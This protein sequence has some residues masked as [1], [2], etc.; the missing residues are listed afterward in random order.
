MT[1]KKDIESMFTGVVGQTKA[2]QVLKFYIEGHSATNTIPHMM[3]VAPK[4][5]GKTLMARSLALNLIQK[6]ETK[7]KSRVLIN[8]ASV[9]NLEQF[10]DQIVMPKLIDTD[11]T[12]FFDECHM[13]PSDV[14]NALLTV[15]NPNKNMSN[16][17]SFGEF[18]WEVDFRRISFIF[19]TTE[20]QK[21]IDPLMDRCRR[22]DLED[23]T[24]EDL[25]RMLTINVDDK[26]SFDNKSLS[27]IATTLRGNG[28]AAQKMSDDIM[29][30]CAKNRKRKFTLSDWNRL[31]ESLDISPLGLNRT[32]LKVLRALS[33]QPYTKLT[34]LAAKLGMSK[35]S[36]M[37]DFEMYLQKLGLFEIDPL[38]RQLTA[39]GR[40][41][42]KLLDEG[43]VINKK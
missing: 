14:Q 18:D 39:K 22:I 6:G 21:V 34:S 7:C 40:N 26:I 4:G 19:A 5:C 13:I 29:T 37:N 32:E 41:Y 43:I 31:K 1:T 24:H 27:E 28:R 25:Q 30:Y 9:K 42:L 33:E 12:V 20:S 15:L 23:Y 10:F 3:L 36:I 38:G 17:F 2:K 8:C 16:T 35:S 11:V